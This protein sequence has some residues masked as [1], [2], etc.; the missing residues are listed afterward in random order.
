MFR[1]PKNYIP[2]LPCR[3]RAASGSAASAALYKSPLRGGQTP[4]V[5]GVAL[6]YLQM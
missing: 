5:G 3:R 1:S 6:F 2:S 4:P